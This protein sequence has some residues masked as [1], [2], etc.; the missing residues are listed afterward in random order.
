MADDSD[1]KVSE[2]T[3]DALQRVSLFQGCSQET[4]GDIRKK[5]V[6]KSF[7]RGAYIVKIGDIAQEMFFIIEGQVEY[8]D[9]KY[10]VFSHGGSGDFFGELGLLYSI[11]RTANVRAATDVTLLILNKANFEQVRKANEVINRTVEVIAAKRLNRFKYELVKLAF[12]PDGQT[13]TE[14]QV[15]SFKEAF[16]RYTEDSGKL[17]KAGLK[18]L[19]TYLSGKEFSEQEVS[20]MLKSL[21]VDRDGV[22]SFEDFLA[23]IRT[24][25]WLLNPDEAQKYSEKIT[26]EI[27]REEEKKEWFPNFD[28]QSFGLGGVIGVAVGVAVVL[29]IAAAG[30]AK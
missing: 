25:K 17:D 26:R 19:L 7:G 29:G 14:E 30:R 24:V 2:V 15:T 3:L 23:K 4:L 16:Y 18:R 1:E 20:A 8:V 10:R 13:F 6:S 21:D 12:L 11:P 9:A 22:I 5:M 27:E 28:A